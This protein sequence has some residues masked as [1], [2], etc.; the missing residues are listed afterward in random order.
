M[1]CIYGF[2][3][4]ARSS[5]VVDYLIPPMRDFADSCFQSWLNFAN[6]DCYLSPLN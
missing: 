6:Q 4:L 5:I 1:E 3:S 2:I